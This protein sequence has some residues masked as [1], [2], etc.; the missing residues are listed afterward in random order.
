MQF[1][2]TRVSIIAIIYWLNIAWH[3][4]FEI[5]TPAVG[6]NVLNIQ[7]M[8]TTLRISITNT[9]PDLSLSCLLMHLVDTGREIT[10]H[11]K[12]LLKQMC[13]VAS[14]LAQIKSSSK[15]PNIYA[16]WLRTRFCVQMRTKFWLI[17]LLSGLKYEMWNVLKDVY[18]T[19]SKVENSTLHLKNDMYTLP[20]KKRN[21]FGV[22]FLFGKSVH[23][24]ILEQMSFASY[25]PE[26]LTKST[27]PGSGSK[28]QGHQEKWAH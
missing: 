9:L 27:W 28:T 18:L 4:G 17:F 16:L 2:L 15:P 10:G 7:W 22:A 14:G 11:C 6:K 13:T 20:Q 25:C 26:H 19:L 5:L 3:E 1:V 8:A 12:H 21:F 23:H 24:L